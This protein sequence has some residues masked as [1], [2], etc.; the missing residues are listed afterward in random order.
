MML[1]REVAFPV[2]LI[3]ENP[4]SDFGPSCPIEYVEWVRHD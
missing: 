3:T 2:D 1:K 4:N